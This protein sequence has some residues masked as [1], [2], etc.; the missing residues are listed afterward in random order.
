MSKALVRFDRF[1]C[2][3]GRTLRALWPERKTQSGRYRSR[4]GVRQTFSEPAATM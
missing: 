1:G 2:T 3:P 4:T